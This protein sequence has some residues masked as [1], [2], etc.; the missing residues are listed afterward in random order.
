MDSVFLDQLLVTSFCLDNKER[1]CYFQR[2][3]PPVSVSVVV[4]CFLFADCTSILLP[5]SL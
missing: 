1:W 5:W 2:S 3:M 4:F